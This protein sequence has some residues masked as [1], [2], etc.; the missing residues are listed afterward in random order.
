MSYT[1]LGTRI[2][3]ADHSAAVAEIEKRLAAGEQTA[4]FTPNLLMIGRQARG[5][6]ENLLNRAELNV[7]DGSGVYLSLRSR[8]VRG[9]ERTAGIDVA[10]G[11]LEIAAR[12]GLGVYLLGA[13]RG[14]AERAAEK[15]SQRIAGLRICGAH[16]GYFDNQ[17]GGA[18]LTEVIQKIKSSRADVL[19]VC[20]G[21][22]RQEQFIID[23][24]NEL[25]RVRL[26]MALGGSLDVWSGNVRRAPKFLQAL[27]LEWLWRCVLQPAKIKNALSLP[28]CFLKSLA[29]K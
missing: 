19:A 15:L 5:A 25:S 7:A 22:P 29:R 10:Y 26:F 23:A 1:I 12:M 13:E 8:G 27:H 4:L 18:E 3:Y 20:L 21:S 9:I 24:R 28:V 16:H 17:R 2:D 11:A 6:D 14:V